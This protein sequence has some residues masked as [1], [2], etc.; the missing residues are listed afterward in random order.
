MSNIQESASIQDH[1]RLMR[2]DAMGA[3]ESLARQRMLDYPA[4]RPDVSSHPSQQTIV[5]IDDRYF[6]R[7]CLAR[8]LRELEPDSIVR[9]Y[10][11]AEEWLRTAS[12]ASA[13]VVL[14]C[15]T[16]QQATEVAIRRDLD[17][18]RASAENALV[19]VMSD[20]ESP[21]EMVEA[22][23]H[24][25]KGYI[26]MS[27]SLNVAMEA[28]RL[29]R[30]GGTFIPASSLLVAR[31]GASAG[32]ASNGR[33]DLFTER[34]IAVIKALRRGDSNKMIAYNLNMGECTVKVHIRNIMKKIK[35]RN[36]TEVA[37]L[38]KSMFPS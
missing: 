2:A 30:A 35:A 6:A 1:S 8:C 4:M 37:F 11:G 29:V 7:D 36:R 33:G 21:L 23:Q 18:I 12:A 31:A 24:G 13:C 19:I 15:A 38:T 28:I 5:I 26:A 3:H 9:T 10:T 16:G 14:L 34:Q 17:A 22:L 27:V 20:V 25:A 32:A